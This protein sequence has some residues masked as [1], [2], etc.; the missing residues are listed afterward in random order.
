[1]LTHQKIAACGLLALMPLLLAGCGGGGEAAADVS[2][3]STSGGMGVPPG[4]S[5]N[6][7]LSFPQ[8]TEGV[9]SYRSAAQGVY[10][11]PL[12]Y[13]ADGKPAPGLNGQGVWI[14]IID[15]FRTESAALFR[16]PPLSRQKVTQ[17]SGTGA[18]AAVGASTI[19]TCALSHEWSTR[20]TH[21]ELVEQI[22]GGTL[23]ARQ[24]TVSLSVLATGNAA[25]CAKSF[26]GVDSKAL[27]AQL[28]V[29]PTAG[30]AAG[31]SIQRYPVVL[32]KALDEKGQLGTVLGHLDNALADRSRPIR[33]VNMSLG[34]D[35]DT[36]GGTRQAVLEAA[37][38]AYPVNA[39]VDAVITVSAGNSGLPC[40]KETLL[41][42]NLVA[43]AMA[44]QDSTKGSSI[45]VGAL[46]GSGSAQKVAS[47][48]N[49]PGYLSDRFLWAS[50]EAE[51]F[52][53]ASGQWA[54]GT[55][56]ASARVAGAAALLRQKYPGLTS[57]Q[58]A[59]LLLDSADRDMD[60][61]GVADFTGASLTWGRGKLN[62][63]NALRLA[64]ERHK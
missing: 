27:V 31:A 13:T 44:S 1:M 43:V 19:R 30:V 23:A 35:I 48:S 5:A 40:Y 26:Y 45:V 16:F 21:G 25:A 6:A 24:V 60:N 64:A 34:S 3:G 46:S 51:T 11:G 8:L 61:D 54:Q 15:D 22:A 62:L 33:V 57:V 56:F 49:F 32:G 52:P 9:D 7:R 41:G 38:A 47:Y 59:D 10:L 14:G 50:G 18:P 17:N 53:N 63:G 42:C 28:S 37:L 55:S 12:A 36:G 58:I 39:P 4:G 20:W 29:Q 2:D